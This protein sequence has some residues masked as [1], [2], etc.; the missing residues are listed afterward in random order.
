MMWEQRGRG[1]MEQNINKIWFF[2]PVILIRVPPVQ[3]KK[4]KGER[5]SIYVEAYKQKLS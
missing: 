4:P 2:K 5:K 3:E 1:N